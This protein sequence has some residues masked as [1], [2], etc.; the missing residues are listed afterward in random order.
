[1]RSLIATSP[2]WRRSV[3][4]NFSAIFIISV[5]P[6]VLGAISSGHI[7]IFAILVL[8]YNLL[9]G[10]G[11]QMSFGHSAYFGMGAYGTVIFMKHITANFY[12]GLFFGVIVATVL[13]LIFGYVSLRRRGIYFAMITLALAQMVYFTIL[14]VRPITGGQNGLY[15]PDVN[16]PILFF[17]PL[18]SDLHFYIFTALLFVLSWFAIRRIIRSPYGRILVA[19]RESETRTRNVG[20]DTDK[21]LLIAFT[22]SG[23]FSGLAGGLYAA[24]FEF[25]APEIVFWTLSGEIVFIAIIGG[26]GTLGGPLTGALIFVLISESLT[27]LTSLWQIPFGALIVTIVLVAPQGIYGILSSLPSR[28]ASLNRK[29]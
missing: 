17:H 16:A 8:G 19:T 23:V 27:D 12:F 15:I 28:L 11:G 10:Y 2:N 14:Q 1:M 21:I 26:T 9:L 25:I 13:A 20:F 6:L 7:I 22:L 4:K 24:H 29:R 5:L 18:E 3:I